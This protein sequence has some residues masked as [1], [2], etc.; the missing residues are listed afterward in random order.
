MN[1]RTHCTA[2]HCTLQALYVVN[3]TDYKYDIV[4]E[5]QIIEPMCYAVRGPLFP[6]SF[7]PICPSERLKN[8]PSTVFFAPPPPISREGNFGLP[9]AGLNYLRFYDNLIQSFAEG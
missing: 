8:S 9:S 4:L 5:S 1:S 3:P 7:F 6:L 2:L